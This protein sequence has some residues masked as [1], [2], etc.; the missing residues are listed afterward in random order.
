MSGAV[1]FA[2][3]RGP[4]AGTPEHLDA[5]FW[6]TPEPVIER[7]LDLAVVGPDDN[8]FDLGCGDGRIL[9]A[10][11]RR[12]ARCTGIERDPARIAEAAAAIAAAG[13]QERI[14]LLQDDLFAASLEGATIVSLYL[15]PHVNILLETRLRRELKPG[16]RVIGHAFPFPNWSPA[17]EETIDR[18]QIYLWLR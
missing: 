14:A 6:T 11:A 5:P 4:F 1:P 18:R 12:G 17:R 13:L 9:I 3:E 10:A 7:M 16:A 8:L 15:L 2:A